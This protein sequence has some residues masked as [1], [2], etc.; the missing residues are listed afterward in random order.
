[1]RHR[2]EQPKGP[3]EERPLGN[4]ISA[5]SVE[6]LGR[7]PSVAGHPRKP[8]YVEIQD[9]STMVDIQG[10]RAT[11][12]DTADMPDLLFCIAGGSQF[13]YLG[14]CY[15]VSVAKAV[16]LAEAIHFL[17][18]HT[19]SSAHACAFRINDNGA[20]R[21]RGIGALQ[22]LADIQVKAVSHGIGVPREKIVIPVMLD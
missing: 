2:A 1:E 21:V 19:Q 12:V 14:H 4:M 16:V 20:M 3:L 8:V 10:M 6:Y 18:D 17:P 11:G 13:G 22:F 15:P 5:N 7:K 9:R